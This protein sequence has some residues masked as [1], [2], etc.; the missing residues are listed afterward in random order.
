MPYDL[1]DYAQMLNARERIAAYT[2]AIRAAVKP[3]SVVLEIGCGTGA[4]ALLACKFGARRVYAIEPDAAINL[5]PQAARDNGCAD[6]IVFHH[7]LST[8]VSLPER[9]DVLISDL[10]GSIPLYGT[11]LRDLMDARER[12]LTP[13]ATWICQTDTF[14][15]AAVEAPNGRHQVQAWWDGSR[16]GLDLNSALRYATNSLIRQPCALES[17]VTTSAAWA[18]IHYPTLRSPHAHGAVVLTATR[19]AVAH[20]LAGWF[21][22]TLF[23]GA[24][25]SNAPGRTPSVYGNTFLPWPEAVALR[26]GDRVEVKIDALLSGSGYEWNWATTVR[27]EGQAQPIA[28]FKQSTLRGHIIDPEMLR[29]S[30]SAY[31]PQVTPQAEEERFLL[32][33]IDGETS[34]GDLAAALRSR[35]PERFADQAAALARVLRT[36][37]NLGR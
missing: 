5:G 33:R 9:C 17:L 2:E 14:H 28:E 37:G 24:R 27:R 22:A 23:G 10:R 1:T 13:E 11:H 31:R 21:E 30:S 7:A 36:T 12:L 8:E 35:F 3:G 4:M 25:F 20:G 26:T 18:S 32:E 15:L 34:Q 6:R 16:W 29:R 19:D